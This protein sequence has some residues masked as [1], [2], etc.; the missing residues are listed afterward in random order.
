M[1]KG[2]RCLAFLFG[3]I[4]VSGFTKPEIIKLNFAWPADKHMKVTY[5]FTTT[6]FR[7]DK[8]TEVVITGSNIYSIKKHPKGLQ[9][10]ISGS[11][12]SSKFKGTEENPIQEKLQKFFVEMSNVS[13]SYIVDKNG[14]LIDVL[15]VDELRKTSMRMFDKLVA[16]LPDLPKKEKISG[17]LK[18]LYSKQRLLD[19]L[20]RYWSRD[21]TQWVGIELEQGEVYE[22]QV[23]DS[24][25]FLGKNIEVPVNIHFILV[26]RSACNDKDQIYNCVEL[27][28]ETEIDQEGTSRVLKSLFSELG[29]ELPS[30]TN[31]QI[32]T[33]LKL[34]TE[35]ETLLPHH[36]H[37][38]KSTFST[39]QG[40]G[41]SI[42]RKKEVQKLDYLY[43]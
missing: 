24:I 21:V 33:F 28:V 15:K 22:A 38:I 14:K 12:V 11:T 36:V 26:G 1:K 39:D 25:Q 27:R 9:V 30:N 37:S 7:N 18:Q 17:V 35:P 41:K 20:N 19:S 43:Q 23:N 5:T 6:N 40:S 8:E 29:Q 16:D 42:L 4:F 34:I 13:P 3:F 2:A 32:N 31:I 10:D